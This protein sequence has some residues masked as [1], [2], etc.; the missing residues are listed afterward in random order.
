M[1]IESTIIDVQDII[2][3]APEVVFEGRDA[4]DEECKNEH[5]AVETNLEG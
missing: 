4:T 2:T 5:P 1:S 3:N